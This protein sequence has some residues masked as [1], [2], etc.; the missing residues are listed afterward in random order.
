MQHPSVDGPLKDMLTSALVVFRAANCTL[1][2][3]GDRVRKP[4]F[5]VKNGRGH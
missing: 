2:L 5:V 4:L 1:L 3:G